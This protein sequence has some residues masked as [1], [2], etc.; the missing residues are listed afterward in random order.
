MGENDK[1]TRKD[2]LSSV[3][4][5]ILGLAVCGAAGAAAAGAPVAASQKKSASIPALPFALVPAGTLD[6]G[7]DKLLGIAIDAKGRVYAAGA[8][9]VKIFS[10]EGKPLQTIKTSGPAVAVAI[11]PEGAIYAAQRAR[12]EKFNADGTPAAV[13]GEK[14]SGPGK[15]SLA[16]GI[17]AGE[18]MVYVTDSGA[19]K[20]LCFTPGGD[21]AE[22]ITGPGGDDEL[23][24]FIPSAFFDCKLDAK[25]FL[26]VGHTGLHCVERYDARGKLL[27]HWGKYG[28]NPEDFCGCCNPTNIALF[29]DGRVATTEKGVPRLKVYDAA[30][31]LLAYLGENEF[32]GNA[33]GMALAIDSKNRIA[34]VEP[35]SKKIR[36]YEVKKA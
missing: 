32:P 11:D 10:P 12:I 19:R 22:E 28:P 23:G 36:F 26:F 29:E 2:F 13:W 17:A 3:G 30:G 6:P 9:G 27:S 20:I 5:G 18:R 24:F 33:A 31:R 1:L 4:K 35:I 34:M 7:L 14:G 15:L 16:T 21:F 25:G 8:A